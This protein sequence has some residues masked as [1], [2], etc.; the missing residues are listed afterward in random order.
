[1]FVLKQSDTYFWPVTV[2]LPLSGG[3]KEKHSFEVEFK[4]IP[5]SQIKAMIDDSESTDVDFCRVVMAGWK[6]VV[7]QDGKEIPFTDGTRDGLIDIPSVAQ[8]VLLAFLDANS[9]K[10][11]RKN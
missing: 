7:D 8:A 3:K 5:Q 11:Q 2:E 6:G 10:A 9:G 4:R 1:M